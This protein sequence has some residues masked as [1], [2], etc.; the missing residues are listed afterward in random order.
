[1]RRSVVPV[2]DSG[3]RQTHPRRHRTAARRIVALIEHRDVVAAK[4]IDDA[5]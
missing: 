5:S 3:A 4:K 1:M 2:S